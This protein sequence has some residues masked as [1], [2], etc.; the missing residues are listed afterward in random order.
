METGRGSGMVRSFGGRVPKRGA[1][2][3]IADNA[4]IIGDVSLA[5]GVSIWFGSTLRGDIEP[6]RIGQDSNVQDGVI[7]HTDDG[8]PADVGRR[9]TIGHSA[10]LHGALVEY[11][12][13]P[14]WGATALSGP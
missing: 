11:R 12:A 7:M 10:V 4:Q 3:F 1:R 8:Y 9:V 13:S 14:G 6:I 2:V 5:D